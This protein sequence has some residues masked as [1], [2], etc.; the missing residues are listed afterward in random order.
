M[1]ILTTAK[2]KRMRQVIDFLRGH[3]ALN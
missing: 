2:P 3:N 1:I